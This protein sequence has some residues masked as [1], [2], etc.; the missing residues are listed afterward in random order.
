MHSTRRHLLKGLIAMGALG[1][2]HGQAQ[3]A[4][5]PGKASAHGQRHRTALGTSAAFDPAGR[6]WTAHLDGGGEGGAMAA[7]NIVLRSSSDEGQTW[8]EAREVLRA[9]E[10]VEAA[11]ES[12]PKLAFGPRG[13]IYVSYTRPLGKPYSGDIRFV[14]SLDGGRSFTEP[15][16]VQRDRAVRT[17]RFDSLLVDRQGRV[18]V[19]WIDK[20]DADAARAASR[21]YRGAA[22][23]YAM[24]TDQGASFGPDLRLVDHTCECCRIALTLDPRGQV[25]ALWRHVYEP[26]VRDHAY[27]V[28]PADA[29]PGGA[30]RASF[31]DWQID[32]C[33]HHGPA[34][35]F[36]PDGVRHQVWF[37]AAGDEGGL[38]YAASMASGPLGQPVRL[39]GPQAGHGEVAAFGAS[40]VLVWKEFDGKAT[41][42]KA[43]WRLD[44]GGWKESTVAS[45]QGAS[46]HP[47]LA[48]RGAGAWL[49]WRT[50]DEGVLVRRVGS[51]A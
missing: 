17:H 50:A 49:V 44:N 41:V 31:E 11:G 10:P 5:Q 9:P 37:S 38:F 7:V 27:A 22:L 2:A 39:G 43:R 33:P 8:S 4:H 35:A 47:H 28:L 13:E 18:F 14:R 32:A 24:S 1:A 16:T 46:D 3:T 20:R 42:V 15:I 45:T 23:Y 29:A 21:P 25:A 19:A 26:G 34:L 36:G 40:V 12:R 30:V 48:Q 51:G 6:L